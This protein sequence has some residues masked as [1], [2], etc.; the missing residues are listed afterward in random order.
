MAVVRAGAAARGEE[1]IWFNGA[2]V[3][4]RVSMA[5]TAAAFGLAEVLARAGHATPL[6]VDPCWETFQVLEG[7]MLFH[8]GGDEIPVAAGDTVVLPAGTPHAFLVTTALVRYV[9]L[10]VPGGHDRFFR[11]GGDPAPGAELPPPA[12]P[13]LARVAA[14]AAA[15]G[16]KVLG[17]P[18]F[19]RTS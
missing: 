17:P 19:S 3:T 1:H 14:A 7:G 10:T 11:L 12:P 9:V 13:D 15:V 6:H 2:L 8:V 5:D 4:I 16:L 18:P